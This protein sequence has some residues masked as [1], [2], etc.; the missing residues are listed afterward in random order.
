MNNKEKIRLQHIAKAKNFVTSIERG[1]PS[2]SVLK[3]K[4]DKDLVDR[5]FNK[6]DRIETLII[7]L[8]T[9]LKYQYKT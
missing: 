8:Y 1:I 4:K 6:L 7:E 2:K 9:S 3:Y 5:I